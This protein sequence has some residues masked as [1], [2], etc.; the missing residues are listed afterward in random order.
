MAPH[1]V[2][3]HY[4]LVNVHVIERSRYLGRVSQFEDAHAPELVRRLAPGER[5]FISGSDG[6]RPFT[7]VD[8]LWV[9]GTWIQGWSQKIADPDKHIGEIVGKCFEPIDPVEVTPCE[10]LDGKWIVHLGD[11]G[12]CTGST[13][14]YLVIVK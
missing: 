5:A 1:Q 2:V 11:G 12:V 9:N 4:Q 13:V 7:V 14:L 8:G 10:R 3:D 6:L